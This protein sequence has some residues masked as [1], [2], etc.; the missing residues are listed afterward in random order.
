MATLH[1]IVIADPKQSNLTFT[2]VE[3]DHYDVTRKEDARP[4][5]QPE[6]ERNALNDSNSAFIPAPEGGYSIDETIISMA[7][8]YSYDTEVLEADKYLTDTGMNKGAWF[9]PASVYP[10]PTFKQVDR[11]V[12]RM[13]R[14]PLSRLEN[15]ELYAR[16]AHYLYVNGKG[17]YRSWYYTNNP[18]KDSAG[19]IYLFERPFTRTW[20]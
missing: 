11:P 1:G 9:N 12:L 6:F 20:A 18:W 7:M 15:P 5:E 2:R 14:D 3:H 19:R 8:T 10:T 4:P 17:N 13:I 16:Q